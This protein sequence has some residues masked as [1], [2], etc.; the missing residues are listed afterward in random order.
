MFYFSEADGNASSEIKDSSVTA[1]K[2]VK[3]PMPKLDAQRYWLQNIHLFVML[4]CSNSNKLGCGCLGESC[5]RYLLHHYPS[6]TCIPSC[7]IW[8][9]KVNT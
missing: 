6:G 5:P 8:I 1:Q 9:L 3:R 7:K 4:W 2:T